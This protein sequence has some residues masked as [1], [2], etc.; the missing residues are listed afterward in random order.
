MPLS[1]IYARSENYCIGHNGKVPWNLPDE[2]SHFLKVIKGHAII[3]GRKSYEDHKSVIPNCFNIVISREKKYRILDEVAL[4]HS[5]HAAVLQAKYYSREYF[6][7]GGANLLEENFTHAQKVYETVVETTIDG[8]T[9]LR[10]LDFSNFSSMKLTDHLPDNNHQY[11]FSTYL[12][13][14]TC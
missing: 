11:G 9:H 14:R 8:D 6:L 3:M 13:Q 1:L 12:H 4:V 2:F 10:P 7:I 5:F